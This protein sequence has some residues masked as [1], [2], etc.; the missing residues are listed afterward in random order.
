MNDK[1]Q[2]NDE[3]LLRKIMQRFANAE[4]IEVEEREDG[5]IRLTAVG[6]KKQDDSNA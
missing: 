6:S 5:S 2:L 1:E 4:K 3:N